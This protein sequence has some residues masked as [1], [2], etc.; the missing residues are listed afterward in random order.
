MSVKNHGG[1]MSEEHFS[2]VH[3]SSLEVLPAVIWYQAGEQ[4]KGMIEFCFAKCFYSYF[5]SEIYMP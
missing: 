5:P 3:Q 4:V 1:M 2:F